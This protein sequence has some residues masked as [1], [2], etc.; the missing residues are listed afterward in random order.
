MTR[1]EVSGRDKTVSHG[2]R[3]ETRG[4]GWW[5]PACV[6]K[7]LSQSIA[8]RRAEDADS[9][10][11]AHGTIGA[12]APCPNQGAQRPG[13]EMRDGAH[14]VSALEISKSGFAPPPIVRDFSRPSAPSVAFLPPT[15]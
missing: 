15:H 13:S 8:P 3:V 14:S 5:R 6:P 1:S 7:T 4:V 11:P 9:T 10:A 2:V 12:M